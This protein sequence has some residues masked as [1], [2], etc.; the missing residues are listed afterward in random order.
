MKRVTVCQ[1]IISIYLLSGIQISC[2]QVSKD[3]L[4]NDTLDILTGIANPLDVDNTRYVTLGSQYDFIN[5]TFGVLI[6]N[7]YDER[8][9]IHFENFADRL[10]FKIQANTSFNHD[11]SFETDLGWRHLFKKLPFI[12]LG[13]KQYEYAQKDFFH[14]DIYATAET[15]L[16]RSN[17]AIKLKVGYQTLNEHENI[18]AD[19][20][21]RKVIVYSRLYSGVSVGYHFD[22]FTYSAYVQG[23]MY[24]HKLGYRLQYE[25]IGKFDFLK[26]GLIYTF[27][28]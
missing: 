25:N 14:N 18:G 26:L 12:S 11:F 3:S 10:V 20:E 9:L 15:F 4:K 1:V 19:I 17:I 16:P 8:P 27:T 28:R 6:S 22:Y 2:G 21:L 23:F 5:S 13:F 24:K 7:G